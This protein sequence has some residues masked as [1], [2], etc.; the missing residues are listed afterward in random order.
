[1]KLHGFIIRKDLVFFWNGKIGQNFELCAK[2]VCQTSWVVYV[3]EALHPFQKFIPLS[4]VK[5]ASDS[6]TSHSFSQNAQ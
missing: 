4:E 1:M 3:L 6:L 2:C 5:Q